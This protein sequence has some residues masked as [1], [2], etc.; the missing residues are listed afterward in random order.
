[1]DAFLKFADEY[2]EYLNNALHNKVI[3][4]NKS[5]FLLNLLYY[6]IVFVYN[7]NNLF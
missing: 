2:F 1:M 3:K 7:K 4:N 6:F 5:K